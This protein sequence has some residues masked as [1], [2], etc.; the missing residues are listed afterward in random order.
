MVRNIFNIVA[1]TNPRLSNKNEIF[2][3]LMMNVMF[4]INV[5][6]HD[7]LQLYFHL[8]QYQL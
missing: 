4:P 2:V 5:F 6:N 8:D 7:L 3:H 1:K